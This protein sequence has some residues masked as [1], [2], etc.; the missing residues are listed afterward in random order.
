[1][2]EATWWQYCVMIVITVEVAM[3][4]LLLPA[5]FNEVDWQLCT[6]CFL[7]HGLDLL[8]IYLL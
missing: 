5:H 3:L 2:A 1:M 8:H 7:Q 4:L 6:V